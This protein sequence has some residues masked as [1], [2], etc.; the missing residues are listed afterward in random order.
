MESMN[1][2][3]I[4]ATSHLI[5]TKTQD[6]ISCDDVVSEWEELGTNRSIKSYYHVVLFGNAKHLDFT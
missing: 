2:L 5:P 3:L 6:I 1:Y 4:N